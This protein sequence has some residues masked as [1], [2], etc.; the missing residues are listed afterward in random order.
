MK[1][2]I[3]AAIGPNR[4][5]GKDNKLLWQIPDDLKHFKKI[6]ENHV[7]IMGRKTFQSLGK[8]LPKRANIVITSDQNFKAENIQVVHS[9]EQAIEVAK[10]S[11]ENEAFIIGGGQIYKQAIELADKLY[12]TLVEARLPSL[13]SGI[14]GQADTFFPDY[15]EFKKIISEEKQQDEKYFFSFLELTR[16]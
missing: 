1:L 6:T 13:R 9:L 15:S 3:I 12:L 11:G 2:S 7:V 14:S 10:N 4:E 16:G 8:A 5:L